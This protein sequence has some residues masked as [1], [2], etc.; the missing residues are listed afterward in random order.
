MKLCLSFV[1]LAAT[2]AGVAPAAQ[3]PAKAPAPAAKVAPPVALPLTPGS[4][5]IAL[6]PEGRAIAS[7]VMS[8][9]DPRAA[10]IQAELATLRQQKAVVIAGPVIDVDKLEAIMRK[11]ETLQSEFRTRSNDRLLSLLRALPEGDRL[12]LVQALV[13]PAKPQNSGAPGTP[14]PASP[15]N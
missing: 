8:T 15:G 5:R 10:A 13:N 9:A 1:F 2:V 14:A 6:S 11:E 12:A 3:P 4:R 7:R